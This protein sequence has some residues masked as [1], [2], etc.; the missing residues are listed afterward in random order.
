MKSCHQLL[1]SVEIKAVSKVDNA[2]QRSVCVR[3][4]DEVYDPVYMKTC[5]LR[6]ALIDMFWTGRRVR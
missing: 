2:T 4:W 1:S 5:W 6:G 3:G